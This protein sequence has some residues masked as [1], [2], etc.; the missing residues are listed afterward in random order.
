MEHHVYFWLN[1]DK[2]NPEDRAAFEGG[3]KALFEIKEVAGGTWATPAPTAVRPVTENTWDYALSVKFD[4][5]ADH[6]VYQA[7]PDHDVFVDS[8]KSWWS[9]VQVMDL[10]EAN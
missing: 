5:L 8:F 7:H 6:D 4:S 2:K 9:R 1:E 10:Q 3:L